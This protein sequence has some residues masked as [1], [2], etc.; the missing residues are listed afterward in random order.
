LLSQFGRRLARPLIAGV[1]VFIQWIDKVVAIC[2]HLDFV[3]EEPWQNP[4][5]L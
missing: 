1:G 5:Q 2:D 3:E 4:K